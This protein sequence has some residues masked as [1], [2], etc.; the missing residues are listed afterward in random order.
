MTDSTILTFLFTDIEGSTSKWEEQPDLMARAVAR[1]DALLR[2]TVEAHRGKIVKTTGD[3]IYAAFASPSDCLAAVIDIQLALLDPATTA[4]MA[5]AVRCGIHTGTVHARDDDYF[6]STINR[7]ARIMGAAHG[8]QILVSHAVADLLSDCLPTAVTLKGLGNVHLKGLAT[9]EAVFQVVHPKLHQNFPALRELE[10]TPN[11]LPQQLTTFIGRERERQEIEG[12]LA[13]TRLLTLLGMGGLGKTRLALQVGAGVM[14]SYPDGVWFVD[15]QT[16]RDPALVVGETARVLSVREEGGR[17][18]IQ[19][20]CAHLKSRK[21]LLILD[22][23]EQVADASAGLAGMILRTT[24]DVRILATSRTALRVPGEQTYLVQPLPVPAR[25]GTFEALSES[26]AVQ[27]FVERAKLH[28]PSFALTEREAPAVAELVARLEGIPLALELAAARVRSLGL[29]EINKRL[30]DRFKLLVSG[31]RTLQARQQTLRA[32]VDWS[33]DLL[34]ENEQILLARI[35]VFAGN[36]DLAA[37]ETICGV[38]PLTPDDII[39]LITSLVEKSLINME[40][41]DEGARYRVLETIRDYAREKLALRQEQATIAALHCNYYFSFAKASNQGLQG[42]EQAAWT[43]RVERNL[44]DLRAAIALA[45]AGGVDP[46][47]SVKLEVALMGFWMLRGYS[48]EGRRYVRASLELPEVR[49]SAPIHAHALYVGACLAEG[50]SNYAEAQQMLQACLAL[51]RHL[52]SP[53]DIA[54]SLSTLSLVRLHTGDADGARQDEEEAVSIFRSIENRIGEAI[55]LLHLGQIHFYLEDD[56]QANEYFVQCLSIAREIEYREIEREAELL[57]GESLLSAGEL[58]AA[59][60]RFLRSLEVCQDAEDK[61]GEA[62]A[63]WWLGKADLLSERFAEAHVRLNG[64]M[65][66]FRAFEMYEELLGCLDDQAEL[67][68]AVDAAADAVRVFASV[69]VARE[70]LTLRRYP[71]L[72]RRWSETIAEVRRHLGNVKFEQAWSE[73]RAL[74]IDDAISHAYSRVERDAAQAET[75]RIT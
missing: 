59:R 46:I 54:A 27:L 51:R 35:A 44:D 56:A 55:G 30:Q 47:I 72:Q 33:F 34:Q 4:G 32:L 12:F 39:D 57:L 9:P 74:S 17:A 28:K 66:A 52:N 60:A 37:A 14:D 23:C 45:L 36:F 73:G 8:A 61:R 26:T 75:L 5:L 20:L 15:L 21:L 53:I 63:L 29:A 48:S 43:R 11:N 6:G 22:N 62:A 70:R 41:G 42:P 19:T 58:T 68:R 69:E 49:A 25:S 1:H 18:P 3:G 24:P 67:M 40:E 16:I 71:R 50:Q 64:A 2:D 10:A 7:T 13:G 31:D 65:R 38:A